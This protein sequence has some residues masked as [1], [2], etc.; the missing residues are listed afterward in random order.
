MY[1]TSPVIIEKNTLQGEARHLRFA[2]RPG[3]PWLIYPIM[4][5]VL[6]Y[7]IIPYI[8]HISPDQHNGC[9]REIYERKLTTFVNAIGL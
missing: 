2:S 4:T 5:C 3:S 8:Y 9:V 7:N 6:C 1:R